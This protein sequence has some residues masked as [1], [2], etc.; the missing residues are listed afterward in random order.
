MNDTIEDICHRDSALSDVQI[1]ILKHSEELLQFAG[2]L[3]HRELQLFVPGKKENTLVLV[4]WRT[5][6]SRQST[7]INRERKHYIDRYEEPV[8][9][10]VLKEGNPVYAGRE[11]TYGHIEPMYAYPFVD[12]AGV[13]ICLLYTSPSPRDS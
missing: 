12:N 11:V 8:L 1:Q 13:T 5:P 10:R 9:Y 2:D 3:S 6:F 7:V 4:A